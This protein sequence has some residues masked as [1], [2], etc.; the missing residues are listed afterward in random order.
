MTESAVA[1]RQRTPVFDF[2]YI[3]GEDILADVHGAYLKLKEMA[4]E[5]DAEAQYKLGGYYQYGWASPANFKLA[6][7]WYNRAAA[8]GHPDAML[9][10]AIMDT[11]GQGGPADT[12]A[13]FTWLWPK[14]RATW[15]SI[16]SP[17]F[18]A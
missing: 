7:E 6:R 15:T 5:G 1:E 13:A 16:T 14:L 10:L 4:P 9:G 8:Q 18:P 3:A 12:K 11:Q 17:L 2:D